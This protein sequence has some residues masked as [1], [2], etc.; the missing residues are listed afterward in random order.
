MSE[1]TTILSL[2]ETDGGIEVHMSEKAYDNF[3]LIG[4]LERIKMDLLN[5]PNPT[6]H[7]LRPSQKKMDGTPSYEA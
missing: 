5:R 6:L 1:S 4:L 3:A 7:D 2:V